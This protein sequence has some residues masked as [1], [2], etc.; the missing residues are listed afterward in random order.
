MSKKLVISALAGVGVLTGLYAA[1]GYVGVPAGI[2]WAL[3]NYAGSALGGR[4]VQIGDIRFDPWN[5]SLTMQD[6]SVGSASDPKAKMITLDRLHADVNGAT[7]FK[8]T[9]IV[10]AIRVEGLRATL[11]NF[12][13]HMSDVEKLLATLGDPAP[14]A[15]F[16]PIADAYANAAVPSLPAFSLSNVELADSSLI[17]KNPKAGK[18]LSLTD[19]NF[20]LPRLSTVDTAAGA[21]PNVRPSFSMNINGQPVKALGQTKDGLATLDLQVAQVDVANAIEAMALDLPVR[22]KSL[23]AAVKAKLTYDL[24]DPS[25]TAATLSG[26]LDAKSLD[27]VTTDKLYSGKVEAF[28]VAVG[29]LDLNKRTALVDRVYVTRPVVKASFQSQGT[30]NAAPAAQTKS[31]ATAGMQQTWNWTVTKADVT[32]G[33][34]TLTDTSLKP[35]ASLRIKQLDANVA[36][37]T[38]NGKTPGTYTVSMQFDKGS[39]ASKGSLALAPLTFKGTTELKQFPFSPLNPW[40]ETLSGAR[41]DQG[42]VTAQGDLNVAQSDKTTI[43]WS[44]SASVDNFTAKKGQS[45]LVSWKS[46]AAQNVAVSLA[47]RPDI[48][49]GLVKLEDPLQ[50]VTKK[51]DKVLSL[52]SALASAAGRTKTAEKAEKYK[53]KSHRTIEIKDI[54]YSNDKFSVKGYDQNSLEALAVEKLNS[55]F[56]ARPTK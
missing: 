2:K 45:T 22:V 50:E 10:D 42:S 31:G 48:T 1:L 20:T 15:S 25:G 11:T 53:A 54:V 26:S 4:S 21:I 33:D 40:I 47:D 16:A 51:T 32:K 49:I 14:R 9:P 38:S 12:G 23:K 6:L 7:L 56:G 27:F 8:L 29:A 30:G 36:R 52:I 35:A 46:V 44:G 18:T 39:L 37:L 19:I 55:V 13:Q 24:N 3:D 28:G 5:W 34:I 43:K 41:I 17:F